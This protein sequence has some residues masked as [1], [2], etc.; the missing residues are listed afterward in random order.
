MDVTTLGLGRDG[1]AHERLANF[2][3]AAETFCQHLFGKGC[4]QRASRLPSPATSAPCSP[5]RPAVAIP[6]FVCV[7]HRLAPQDVRMNAYVYVNDQSWSGF[8]KKRKTAG[9]STDGGM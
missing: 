7:V 5:P 2:D 6:L 8:S 4:A 3:F 1:G 9:C